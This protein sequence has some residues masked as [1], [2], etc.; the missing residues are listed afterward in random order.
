MARQPAPLFEPWRPPTTTDV[1]HVA[2]LKALQAGTAT[3]EQQQ[4]AL[5]FILRDVCG[6]Y[7]E[8]FCPGEDGR[9]STDYAL[10]KRRVATYLVSLLNADLQ[11]FKTDQ[12]PNEQP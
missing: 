5:D 1:T 10:G 3:A 2:A 6:Y 8:Q 11:R 12:R 4:R 9:R 7:D